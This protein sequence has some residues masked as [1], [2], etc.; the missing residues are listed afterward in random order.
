MQNKHYFFFPFWE[1]QRSGRG[2][3]QAGWAKIPTFTK[4]LFWRLPSPRYQKI[5]TS[6][7]C[8][9]NTG[10]I[11]IFCAMCF[12]T[13]QSCFKQCMAPPIAAA[14]CWIVWWVRGGAQADGVE[15]DKALKLGMPERENSSRPPV[16]YWLA[17][18]CL[19]PLVPTLPARCSCLASHCSSYT[20][21]PLL[22]FSLPLGAKT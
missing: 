7:S 17:Q 22:P 19:L 16:P 13:G 21:L 8:K 11:A 1:S 3:G 6:V 2:G 9:M 12:L 4:N 5:N 18:C 20:K 10:I 14:Q 15:A